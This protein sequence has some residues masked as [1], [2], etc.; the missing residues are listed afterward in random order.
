MDFLTKHWAPFPRQLATRFPVSTANVIM[1]KGSRVQRSFASCNFSFVLRGVGDYRQGSRVWQVEAPCVLTQWPGEDYDYGPAPGS[2]WDEAFFIYDGSFAAEFSRSRLLESQRPIW[3]IANP[4]QVAALLAEFAALT[5]A[6]FPEMVVDR[7]DRVAERLILESLL[8]PS[9]EHPVGRVI[10]A[11]LGEVRRNLGEPVDFERIARTCAMSMSTFRRR[12]VEEIGVPPRR[13]VQQ[14]RLREACRRLAETFVPI[15]TVAHE[16]GFED[17][18]Y[19]SRYF[20][21]TMGLS[22]RDYRRAHRIRQEMDAPK[23]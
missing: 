4:A 16:V 12:W 8:G 1:G 9:D 11:V 22:P 6:S 20:H 14:I 3:P 18:L 23:R 7:I 17:E 15:K 21:R 13:Y 10:Q 2:T 19:F 5:T